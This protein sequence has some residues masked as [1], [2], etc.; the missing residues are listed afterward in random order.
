MR[1]TFSILL[2]AALV[3]GSGCSTKS[4]YDAFEMDSRSERVLT[5]LRTATFVREGA[6]EAV[7]STVY[8]N[9]VYPKRY[10]G[11][12]YFYIALY[13][14]DPEAALQGLRLNKSAAPEEV[15]EL[16]QTDQLYSIMPARNRWQRSF[17]VRF[18]MQSGDKL[19]LTPENGRIGTG[20]LDYRKDD[21]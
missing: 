3:G 5:Y 15:R 13:H 4:A 21:R 14:E 19:T 17:L 6:T 1:I 8:L 9:A 7:I 2:A 11:G 20:A 10:K 12:E 16:E 18:A